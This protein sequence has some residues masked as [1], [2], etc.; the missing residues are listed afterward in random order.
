MKE[1]L[2]AV[3]IDFTDLPWEEAEN[4]ESDDEDQSI[5]DCSASQ[6]PVDSFIVS[7]L[8]YITN[9][10]FDLIPALELAVDTI[11]TRRRKQLKLSV[12]YKGPLTIYTNRIHQRYP[13]ADPKIIER[14]AEGVLNCYKKILKMGDLELQ[15]ASS[16]KREAEPEKG[17]FRDSGLATSTQPVIAQRITPQPTGPPITTKR[18]LP[19]PEDHGKIPLPHPKV[20]VIQR[21]GQPSV[22]SSATIFSGAKSLKTMLGLDHLKPPPIPLTYGEKSFKCPI[23]LR[24]QKIV[25]KASWE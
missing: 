3:V 9:A 7:E 1:A 15:V 4:M 24:D 10:L 12:M 16:I 17:S 13:E 6:K 21:V 5:S 20:R 18:H 2:S 25:D 11:L 8:E 19:D 14:L 22:A 23:C